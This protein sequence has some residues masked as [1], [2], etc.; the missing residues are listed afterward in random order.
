MMILPLSGCGSDSENYEEKIS[1]MQAQL[2]EMS[3]K[4]VD[5][6]TENENLKK[7]IKAYEKEKEDTENEKKLEEA[8]SGE[9]NSNDGSVS[10]QTISLG[11][12]ITKSDFT[13][14]LNSVS[15][16]Y[17]V[18]PDNPTSTFYSHY[19][20]DSGQV[21]V[22]IDADVKNTSKQNLEC[23]EIY[24]VTADYNDGYTYQG[25][26][27]VEDTDGDFT[28]AN[29]TSLKPLQ[30]L[31]IHNLV[32]CPEEI[33][34]NSSAPLNVIIIFNDGTKYKYKVR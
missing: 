31:G 30:T 14:T 19:P 25:F 13:F 2:D 10:A 5:A 23:D 6:N 8:R 7:Q 3:K 34:T 15:L 32:N 12:S 20:A 28:Y 11:Q 1:E 17:D 4:I 29:I 22:H 21:Y 27:V 18:K 16:S 24:S 33:E 26:S 9:L